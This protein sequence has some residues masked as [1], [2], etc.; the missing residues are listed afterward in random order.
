MTQE[1]GY[2]PKI[3][4]INV[5]TSVHAHSLHSPPS[6]EYFRHHSHYRH[7]SSQTGVPRSPPSPHRVSWH[8]PLPPEETRYSIPLYDTEDPAK[9]SFSEQ[10]QDASLQDMPWSETSHASHNSYRHPHA[11]VAI[12][13][14]QP[15]I[16]SSS[17][18]QPDLHPYVCLSSLSPRH[19]MLITHARL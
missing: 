17:R 12:P 13:Q 1:A 19:S 18:L 16:P 4:S 7:S 9:A 2:R 3:P 5:K 6:P 11:M 14:R 10:V 15:Q 8:Y